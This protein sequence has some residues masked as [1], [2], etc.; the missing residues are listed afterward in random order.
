MP[1]HA[2]FQVQTSDPVK[3]SCFSLDAALQVMLQDPFD[4]MERD[5]SPEVSCPVT[6]CAI[7]VMPEPRHVD[8][9]TSISLQ[10]R[11]C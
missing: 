6:C 7:A 4:D 3:K 10:V 11:A 1:D 2:I 9:H 8:M 5:L